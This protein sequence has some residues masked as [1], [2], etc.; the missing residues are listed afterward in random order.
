VFLVKDQ[1]AGRGGPHWYGWVIRAGGGAIGRAWIELSGADPSG[2]VVGAVEGWEMFAATGELDARD[3]RR[4]FGEHLSRSVVYA[5]K[6]WPA[7]HGARDLE[8]DVI[9]RGS[10]LAPWRA[11]LATVQGEGAP[12]P[13]DALKPSPRAAEPSRRCV[14]CGEAIPSGMRGDALYYPE[15][16]RK[17]ASRERT[18]QRREGAAA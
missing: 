17:A 4:T 2:C 7:E 12:E 18:R 1:R 14:R 10:F 16:C 5:F 13:C 6:A 8:R 11:V 9:A 3:S 15:S